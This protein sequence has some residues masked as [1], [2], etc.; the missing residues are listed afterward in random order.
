[1]L[2]IV[3]TPIG[4]MDEITYRA[5][6]VLKSVDAVLCEDTRRSAVLLAHYGVEKPLISYQKFNERAR[7]E[8]IIG[9]LQKGEDLA[10]I[11]DAGMPAISDPGY[12]L[13]CEAVAAGVDYT[14]VSGPCA[15]INALVLSGLDTSKF[16]FIGFLPEKNSDRDKIIAKYCDVEATLIFYLPLSDADKIIA[17]LADKLGDRKCAV[18]REMTKK[19]ESVTRGTLA[20]PPDFV[21]KG[22]FVL[23][24]EGCPDG[25]SR[26]ASL[27]VEQH[28][29]FYTDGGMDRKDAIK[30]VA[31]DRGVSKS[32]IYA[33]LLGGK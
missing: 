15:A 33:A 26:L 5:V 24:V 19:F 30:K 32:E 11:S 14:V 20:N 25:D 29:A 3:A 6:Q 7:S 16:L 12:L 28:V 13:V 2:Y 21:R 4:N 18:V 22:E 1:M 17:Y 23:V 10:L 27:P 8:E 31:R 9:R